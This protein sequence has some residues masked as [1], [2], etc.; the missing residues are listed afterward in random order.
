MSIFKKKKTIMEP[1][2]DI[3]VMMLGA[4]RVGKTSILA[5]MTNEFDEI[6]RGTNLVLTKEQGKQLIINALETMKG[7]FRNN[8]KRLEKIKL[9]NVPTKG[10]SRFDVQL[11]IAN[12]KAGRERKIR[13]LDCAGEF[14]DNGA[15][16]GDIA[17]E[18]E[19][20]SVIIIAIDAVILMEQNGRFQHQNSAENVTNFIK[21]YMRPDEQIN[22]QK[23]VMFV[24]VKCERYYYQNKD[25]SS[26]FYGKKM[27]ELKEKIKEEYSDL[28]GYFGKEG[29]KDYFTTVIMPI[30]TLGGIEFCEFAKIDDSMKII[31]SDK[32]IYQY[33]DCESPKYKPKNCAQPLLY[34]LM[35]ERKKIG[36]DY[37]RRA[38]NGSNKKKISAGLKEWFL[39]KQNKEKD[40]DFLVELEKLGTKLIKSGD[41][42]EIVNNPLGI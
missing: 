33:C 26:I 37:Y 21:K 30:L 19:K 18:I 4:R 16:D 8:H 13:F 22:K 31:T 28:F 36:T 2:I 23:L 27:E 29:N 3:Q 20:S 7:Y 38:F 15:R 17:T 14:M 1:G 12:K 42:I 11:S 32:I 40:E 35:Y 9:D 34:S 41:G 5:S 24:P 6:S 10:F 39:D 25:E